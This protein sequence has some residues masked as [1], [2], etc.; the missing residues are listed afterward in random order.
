[1]RNDYTWNNLVGIYAYRIDDGSRF[2][3]E[4]LRREVASYKTVSKRFLFWRWDIQEPVLE[5]KNDYCIRAKNIAETYS[6]SVNSDKFQAI[7]IEEDIYMGG[8]QTQR[9]VHWKD[10]KWIV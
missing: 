7:T 2:L 5:S 9:V 1:M 8:Y 4:E 10:G 3:I 6:R